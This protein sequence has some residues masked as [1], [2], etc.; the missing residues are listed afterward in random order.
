MLIFQGMGAG[1]MLEPQ[2]QIQKRLAASFLD[3]IDQTLK[4]AQN[5]PSYAINL[6]NVM[7]GADW[8]TKAAAFNSGLAQKGFSNLKAMIEPIGQ[9][10]F[11]ARTDYQAPTTRIES[12]NIAVISPAPDGARTEKVKIEIGDAKNQALQSIDVAEGARWTTSRTWP[13]P[14][15][16]KIS[17]LWQL[18]Y[19]SGWMN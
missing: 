4:Y 7:P 8:Q 6:D 1:A 18:K 2:D 13:R 19:G 17:H 12:S 5:N 15:T 9:S 11:I 14:S 16:P 3:H 10:V